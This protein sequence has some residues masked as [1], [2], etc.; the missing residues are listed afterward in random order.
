MA[1]IGRP[2]KW[3][4]PQELQKRVDDYFETRKKLDKPYTLESLALHLETTPKTL[5]EYEAG[6]KQG[7]KNDADLYVKV[8]KNARLRI[9]DE[10]IS[11][12]WKHP[13]KAIQM[14][15]YL[16]N[17]FGY[18][19]KPNEEA[20]TPALPF[21]IVIKELKVSPEQLR[22]KKADNLKAAYVIKEDGKIAKE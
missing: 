19:D 6:N 16:K 20:K 12:A 15:F 2:L 4:T 18:A 1:R 9:A 21:S 7:F 17:H 11:E 22:L 3:K 13:N 8:L 5:L 10:W 14:F